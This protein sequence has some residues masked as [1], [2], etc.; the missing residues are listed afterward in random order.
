MH[1]VCDCVD[2]FRKLLDKEYHIILEGKIKR[3]HYRL[4]LIEKNVSI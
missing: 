2:A 3:F 1:N 4:I